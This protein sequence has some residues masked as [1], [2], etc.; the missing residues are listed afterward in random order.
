M[1]LGAFL[2]MKLYVEASASPSPCRLVFYADGSFGQGKPFFVLD[3]EINLS[4]NGSLEVLASKENGVCYCLEGFAWKSF[5]KAKHGKISFDSALEGRLCFKLEEEDPTE[6]GT[7]Y[8]KEFALS[9]VD[10]EQKLALYGTMPLFA[11][12][13]RFAFGQFVCCLQGEIV[14]FIIDFSDVEDNI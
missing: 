1:A 13:I 5:S 4:H 14:G 2:V 10:R 3:Y 7:E 8:I 9:L 11:E 12:V 6:W